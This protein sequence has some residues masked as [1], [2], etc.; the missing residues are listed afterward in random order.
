VLRVSL[1][2]R[3]THRIVGGRGARRGDIAGLCVKV[4]WTLLEDVVWFLWA[5]LLH[6]AVCSFILGALQA[7]PQHSRCRVHSYLVVTPVRTFSKVLYFCFYGNTEFV[8]GCRAA[9]RIMR[10]DQL[11][12]SSHFVSAVPAIQYVASHV[13]CKVSAH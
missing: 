3:L 4:A 11:R 8:C 12:E 6:G 7:L 13:H 9:F 5:L 10:R 2:T 1:V